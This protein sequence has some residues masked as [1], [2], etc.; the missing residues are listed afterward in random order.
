MDHL[1]GSK[2]A[3]FE[4]VQCD[5]L[6]LFKRESKTVSSMSKS[7][8]TNVGFSY[9]SDTR[10]EDQSICTQIEQPASAL[11][12]DQKKKGLERLWQICTHAPYFPFFS[13]E[14]IREFVICRHEFLSF[15]SLCV[16]AP[17]PLEK[18]GRKK[19]ASHA[20]TER[21]GK[22][23]LVSQKEWRK[24]RSQTNANESQ[25]SGRGRGN[26]RNGYESARWD[27]L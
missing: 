12:G 3:A 18:G 6:G 25:K 20:S 11:I 27:R 16:A 14:K 8:N 1:F 26:G 5:S 10:E 22:S 23:F 2:K 4:D 17:P 21:R 19:G 24:N 15:F 13:R 9:W 7:R